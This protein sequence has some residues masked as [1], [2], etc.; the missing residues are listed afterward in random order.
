MRRLASAWIFSTGWA[1]SMVS[2]PRRCETASSESTSASDASAIHKNR[3]KSLRLFRPYPSATLDELDT[4]AHRSCDIRPYRSSLW[5]CLCDPIDRCG[6]ILAPL[7]CSELSVRVHAKGIWQSLDFDKGRE[8]AGRI[9]FPQTIDHR[10]STIDAPTIFPYTDT[11]PDAA[12][13]RM[14]DLS[15]RQTPIRPRRKAPSDCLG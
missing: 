11:S 10:P 9:I 13:R 5:E 6:E 7:P 2:R 8:G 15:R 14:T 12:S 1:S 4:L 3:T